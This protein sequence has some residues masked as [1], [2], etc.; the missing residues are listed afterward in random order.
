MRLRILLS[1]FFAVPVAAQTP[2]GVAMN[3]LQS[4][5]PGITAN[6]LKCGTV[7][8]VYSLVWTFTVPTVSYDWLT[9]DPVNPPVQGQVY[10]CIVTAKK[11]A[12]ESDPSPELSFPFPTVP[13]PPAGLQRT[14][15]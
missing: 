13:V 14:E 2:H 12:I 5:T 6:A 8:K 1:L 4:V 3:W 10:F 9:N 15:H 7:T 11:G